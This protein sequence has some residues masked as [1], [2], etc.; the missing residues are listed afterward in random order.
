MN[1]TSLAL[2]SIK[3]AHKI[4]SKWFIRIVTWYR[5]R[6]CVQ[7]ANPTQYDRWMDTA[8]MLHWQYTT[9][10]QNSKASR[11]ASNNRSGN[12]WL[13]GRVP[14]ALFIFV[15]VPLRVNHDEQLQRLRQNLR[16]EGPSQVQLTFSLNN[17]I[18]AQH[19]IH[20]SNNNNTVEI[21]CRIYVIVHF[22]AARDD[23]WLFA[24][25]TMKLTRWSCPS[26]RIIA[27]YAILNGN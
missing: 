12:G 18:C 27:I 4:G 10:P 6:Y 7:T 1:V 23:M 13:S 14:V 2:S 17:L 22:S 9:T 24:M 21:E 25:A 19:T 5:I 15:Y 16:V 8:T 3:E 20:R 11:R 26:W